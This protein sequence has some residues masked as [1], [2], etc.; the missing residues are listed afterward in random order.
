VAHSLHRHVYESKENLPGNSGPP[1]FILPFVIRDV[2]ISYQ[3]YTIL[4]VFGLLCYVYSQL[5]EINE[6]QIGEI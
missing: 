5:Q 2:T 1:R 3:I 4:C 6:I